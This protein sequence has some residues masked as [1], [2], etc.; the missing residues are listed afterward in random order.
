MTLAWWLAL[1]LFALGQ[2]GG[3]SAAPPHK[4]EIVPKN[5]PGE[6]PCRIT[7][8]LSGDGNDDGRIKVRLSGKLHAMVTLLIEGSFTP[9]ETF[10]VFVQNTDWRVRGVDPLRKTDRVGG[11]LLWSKSFQLEPLHPGDLTVPFAPLRLGSAEVQWP[12]VTVQVVTDARPDLSELRD[13]VPPERLP[14]PASPWRWLVVLPVVFIA[15]GL[16]LVGLELRRRFGS[17]ATKLTP[18]ELALAELNQIEAAGAPALAALEPFFTH[19]ADV[20]RRYCEAR[21]RVP[22]PRQTTPEFLEQLQHLPELSHEQ[23][24][25][26]R[27]LFRHADLAK[28]ARAELSAEECRQSL[29]LARTFVRDTADCPSKNP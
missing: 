19:L 16:V 5:Q 21:W 17:R 4:L 26:L 10:E 18:Q 23:R 8:S 14:T 13:I 20:L 1:L 6:L 2:D 12:T 24:E 9:P 25:M 29:Q 22:A 27:K 15:V 3:G 7:L 28:F 11:P